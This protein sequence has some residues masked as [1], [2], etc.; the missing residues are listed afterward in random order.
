[1]KIDHKEKDLIGKWEV[2]NQRVIA[3][4]VCK[5]INILI[6]NYLQ[7]IAGGGWETLFKDPKDGRFWELTYP[8]G[9]MHGGG[10]PRLMNLSD[11][12]ATTKYGKKK[13]G[14][15]SRIPGTHDVT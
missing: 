6:R 14:D 9:H 15:N 12:Q 10:P 7:K 4:D 2:V 8:Q 11:E 13:I 5:R 3:D 1:M